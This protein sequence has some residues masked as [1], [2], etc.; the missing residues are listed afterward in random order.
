[1]KLNIDKI[2]IMVITYNTKE[3][4]L[5]ATIEDSGRQDIE[6][7][8]DIAPEAEKKCLARTR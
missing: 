4:N 5:A 8:S 3:M 6:T 2:K 7:K 1:M